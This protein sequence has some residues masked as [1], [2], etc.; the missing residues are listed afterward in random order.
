MKSYLL[1]ATLLVSCLNADV[2]INIKGDVV[3]S[4]DG[5]ESK[6]TTA[7][8]VAKRSNLYLVTAF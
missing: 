1:A 2:V 3:Y 7:T 5:K 6:A 4:I 8:Q